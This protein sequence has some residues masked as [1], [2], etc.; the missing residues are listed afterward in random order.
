MPRLRV[1]PAR[2]PVEGPPD[3]DMTDEFLA[4]IGPDGRM[5]GEDSGRLSDLWR[6]RY[7]E[8]QALHQAH[9]EYVPRWKRRV[10]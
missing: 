9:P 6:E 5:S 4:A 3:F 7:F 2:E 8:R 1:Q 10:S